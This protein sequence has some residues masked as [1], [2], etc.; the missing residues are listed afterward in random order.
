VN[1]R[2]RKDWRVG[3]HLED[4]VNRE[5]LYDRI[6][7]SLATAC[8]GDALG[9]PTE[10]RSIREIQ[11]T[12]G[13]RVEAFYAPPLDAP[14][15]SGRGAAQFTDDA[16]QM[17]YLV[18]EY[19]EHGGA[20]TPRDMADMLIIWSRDEEYYPRFCGPSTRASIA[21]LLEGG[22][23]AKVGAI[24]R[25][26]TEG[27][28]NGAAMRVAPAGLAHPGDPEAAVRD[29]LTTCLPSHATNHG[30]SGAGAIAAAVATAMIPG[31]PLMEVIRSARWGAREGERL[32]TEYGREVGGATVPRRLDMALE[33]AARSD[34]LYD[35][36]DEI[37][38]TLGSGLPIVEAVPAALG[39]F[40]AANGDPWQTVIAAANL[41]DD[42]DTIGC[43]AGAIAGAFT[44]FGAVPQDA[45]NEMQAANG[46]EVEPRARAFADA[47]AQRMGL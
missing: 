44:G 33:I 27:T 22:D 45:Y 8:I 2:K 20:I 38:L 41:G 31:T 43:M 14:F 21:R 11:E 35:T 40:L 32:G 17:L 47:V 46:M 23:P 18:D 30:V 9:A 34:N 26:T 36:V 12:W 39:V 1:A 5:E 28:S 16:S 3:A 13:G 24:G 15:G 6:L 29:A 25:L 7:G 37:A 19:I 42:T 4:R 10:Q